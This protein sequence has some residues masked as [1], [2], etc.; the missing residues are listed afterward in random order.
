MYQEILTCISLALWPYCV[1]LRHSSHHGIPMLWGQKSSSKS[2]QHDQC[3]AT[4]DNSEHTLSVVLKL[5]VSGNSEGSLFTRREHSERSQRPHMQ[6]VLLSVG[7]HFIKLGN[8]F[9]ESCVSFLICLVFAPPFSL[10]D[11][12]QGGIPPID[13]NP[14]PTLFP[15]CKSPPLPEIGTGKVFQIKNCHEKFPVHAFYFG[16]PRCKYHPN[17]DLSTNLSN[18]ENQ[19]VSC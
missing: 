1:L 5:Q 8:F 2:P 14:P 4:Q 11:F 12:N 15:Q 18:G 13:V 6:S 10:S 7:R 9:G 17:W 19:I 16:P 3:D